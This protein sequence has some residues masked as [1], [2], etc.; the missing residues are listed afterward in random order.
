[1]RVIRHIN[2]GGFGSVD[3]VELPDGRRL[4][5]K[6]FDPLGA[7]FDEREK[8]KRRFEREVR[9]QSQIRHPNVMP[10]LHDDLKAGPPWFTMPLAQDSFERKIVDDRTAGLFDPSPWQDILAAVEELHRLGYVHRDLKPAN[11]LCVNGVWVLSDFGLILPTSRDTTVLTG[12]K[13]AYGTAFFTAPEQLDDFRNT[14]DQ[15]DIFALGCILHEATHANPAR[16]PYAQIR[17]S[18]PYAPILEKCTEIDHK[19]RFPTVAALRAALFDLWRTSQFAPPP[20]DETSL[21]D[22][23]NNNLGDIDAWRNLI[24]HLEKSPSPEAALQAITGAMLVRLATLDDV[25]FGRLMH[26]VCEWASGTSFV[27]AYCD[28]VGDRLLE[29]YPA[30]SVRIKCAI[31]LSALELAISHNRFHVMRQ[32]AAMLGPTAETGLVDRML[33]EMGLDQDIEHRFRHIESTIG[34]RRYE[35]HERIAARLTKKPEE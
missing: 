10:I 17:A 20:A 12:T 26:L 25:L 3:E 27:W 14:P 15:A 21:L 28:V 23:V 13:T 1:M 11:V 9:I 2:R 24:S 22:A 16:I 30:G 33:I 8:L 31:V 5:R 4:A 7:S 35:W 18:G 19:R 6:S 32:V 29:T 34:L